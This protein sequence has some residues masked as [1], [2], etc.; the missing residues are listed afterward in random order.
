[1]YQATWSIEAANAERPSPAACKIGTGMT[2]TVIQSGIAI[3]AAI[4]TRARFK[5]FMFP[6]SRLVSLRPIIA[7]V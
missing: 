7:Q 5:V 6:S 3:S 1:M 2:K 4:T